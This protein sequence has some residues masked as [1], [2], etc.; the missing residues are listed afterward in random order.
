MHPSFST[1]SFQQ[2]EFNTP[3]NIDPSLPQYSTIQINTLGQNDYAALCPNPWDQSHRADPPTRPYADSN[4]V[5]GN[6]NVQPATQDAQ[7]EEQ[8]Y[9][10]SVQEPTEHSGEYIG[11]EDRYFGRGHGSISQT[12][13]SGPH[14][15]TMGNMGTQFPSQE[16]ARPA[17]LMDGRD[18]EISSSTTHRD[19]FLQVPIRLPDD[20]LSLGDL[21]R[22]HSRDITATPGSTRTSYSDP[23]GSVL[24][25]RFPCRKP[26]CSKS[27]KTKNGEKYESNPR[28]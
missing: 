10:V 11:T 27:Y 20:H 22:R 26:W 3:R 21:G 5:N 23:D 14:S 4:A 17:R 28:Y 13:M 24:G 19:E 25:G 7:Y 8:Y 6:Y 2:Q 12:Q 15:L 16:Q 9:G 1:Q 18:L